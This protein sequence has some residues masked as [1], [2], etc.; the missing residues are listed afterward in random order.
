MRILA[1]SLTYPLPNGV[2]S[3]INESID[4]FLAAGHQ[5][6]VVSP[7]YGHGKARLEHTYVQASTIGKALTDYFG[8]NERMFGLGAGA[9][10]RSL[11]KQFR[12]DAFW[13][14]T[15]TWAPNTFERIMLKS[16]LPK[17]LTYHT[18][19]D[20]YARLYGREYGGPLG[21]QQAEKQMIRRSEELGNAVN[22]I[23]TPSHFMASRLIGFGVTKP[24]SV[25]PSGIEPIKGGDSKAELAKRFGF[26]PTA[27]V[28]IFVGRVVREKN[29]DALLP[30][31]A[32]VVKTLPE[33]VLL[34]V[35]PGELDE[36]TAAA[37]KLGIAKNVVF[38]DQLPLEEA[39]RCY[40]G[41]DIFVFASQSETQGLVIGEAMSAGLPVVTLASPVSPEVT[42]EG[43]AIVVKK[44]AELAGAV[45]KLLKN[46][47][48]R[49]ELAKKGQAF[50][51]EHFSKAKMISK[52]ISVFE[53]L[54]H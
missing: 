34:L 28:L 31:L 18:M 12:P 1:C 8:K 17:V 5:M 42:P 33:T 21:E 35:G 50:V 24:I 30:M 40:A 54:L 29:V 27:Q 53:Q 13:L 19:V 10:I 52:Q 39:R 36:M 37:K 11:I 23:I 38:T 20:Y 2:T 22:H 3:S 25:I 51:H 48:E 9:E 14:H 47:S 6:Q 49:D 7:N 44:P 15:V 41:A 4:G 46:K 43:T 16:K 45:V 26:S 32:E